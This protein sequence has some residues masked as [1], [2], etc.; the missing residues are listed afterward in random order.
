MSRTAF[1]RSCFQCGTSV[2]SGQ[3]TCSE[4]GSALPESTGEW[5]HPLVEQDGG[6]EPGATVLRLGAVGET[7]VAVAFSP[8][9]TFRAFRWDGGFLSPTLFAQIVAGPA[10]ALGSALEAYLEHGRLRGGASSLVYLRLLILA[11]PLYVYL[12]AQLLHLALVLQDAAARPLEATYRAVAY[13]NASVA[14]LWLV[15][16]IGSFAFLLAATALEVTALRAAH[17]LSMKRALLTVVVPA[18]ALSTTLLARL[19]LEFFLAD[20][21]G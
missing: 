18:F 12:K 15:P 5:R 6:E 11:P 10:V 17:R 21:L 19:L 20:G 2:S 8:A 14:L 4:C 13:T 1:L 9:K 3:K 7:V 16:V